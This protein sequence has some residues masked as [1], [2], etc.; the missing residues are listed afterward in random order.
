MN[1]MFAIILGVLLFGGILA[2][3]EGELGGETEP[4]EKPEPIILTD[5]AVVLPYED[6]VILSTIGAGITKPTVTDL[7]CKIASN[8]CCFRV[9]QESAI[10]KTWCTI[11][12]ADKTE[13]AYYRDKLI[14]EELTKISAIQK[15]RTDTSKE[16]PV[17]E[18]ETEQIDLTKTEKPKEEP[19]KDP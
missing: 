10:D 5:S 17:V 9:Y 15:N 12:Y 3:A 11:Y 7:G 16:L 19:I 14:Q 13:R 1:K 18:L 2:L 6:T 8:E 4:I